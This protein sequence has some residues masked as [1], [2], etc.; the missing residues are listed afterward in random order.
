[1]RLRFDQLGTRIGRAALGRSGHTI[2][3]E[4]ITPDAHQAD[5]RHEPDPAREAER[6]RLGLLGRLAAVPCLIELYSQAPGAQDLR[7]CLAKHIA[8]WQQ[9]ARRARARRK[10]GEP[11]LSSSAPF[12]WIITAGAPVSSLSELKAEPA[13]GWPAGVHLFGGE[14][15]RAGVVVASELPR[16]RD[17]LLVRLMAAGPLLPEA[18]KELVALPGDA[19]ERAAAL[20]ILL[21]LRHVLGGRPSLRHEEKEFVVTM[22]ETWDQME[23]RVAAETA[24][25]GVLTVLRVRGISVPAATRKRILAQKDA[26]LLERW[27]EKAVVAKTAR[28]VLEGQ[29]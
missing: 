22:Y 14:V 9:R 17:T 25:R 8:F 26:V 15:L 29:S 12:L 10:K 4:P 16:D 7:S 18:I 11:P 23:V 2:A 6:A 1:M 21:D 13:P 24:A 27:L 5:L 3:H 20:R 19:E 28:E